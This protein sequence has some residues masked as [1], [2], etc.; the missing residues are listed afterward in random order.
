[1]RDHF[2]KQV[3]EIHP[4]FFQC[5]IGVQIF[6]S[7]KWGNVPV[8]CVFS[9]AV[10]G[11]LLQ[12]SFQT[13]HTRRFHSA[14]LELV[15][16]AHFGAD[17]GRRLVLTEETCSRDV[18]NELQ[19]GRPSRTQDEMHCGRISPCEITGKQTEWIQECTRPPWYEQMYVWCK[20]LDLAL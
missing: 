16:S 13:T 19:S 9:L 15:Q 10:T 7:R 12:C 2:I 18:F 17:S 3:Q 4:A 1:M 5:T 8:Q 6:W 14:H 11:S 20:V